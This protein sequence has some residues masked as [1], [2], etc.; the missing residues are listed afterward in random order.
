M[1]EVPYVPHWV[2]LT[3]AYI[4]GVFTA[5]ILVRLFL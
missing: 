1:N 3:I 2:E 4:A 5:L